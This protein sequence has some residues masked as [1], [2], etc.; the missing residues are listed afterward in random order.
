MPNFT[1]TLSD[2][3]AKAIELNGLDMNPVQDVETQVQSQGEGTANSMVQRRVQQIVDGSD[4]NAMTLEERE[5]V[6]LGKY[7][8]S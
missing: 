7:P 8:I 5:A 2:A 4:P 6:L 3:Q 1:I